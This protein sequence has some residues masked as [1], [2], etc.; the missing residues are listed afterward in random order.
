VVQGL[1]E[2][3]NGP[4]ILVST[5]RSYWPGGSMAAFEMPVHTPHTRLS[6]DNGEALISLQRRRE[7]AR[8]RAAELANVVTP[9]TTR[10][11]LVL[12]RGQ[13]E[14]LDF[15]T[16]CVRHKARIYGDWRFDQVR[17][18]GQGIVALFAGPSGT[19]KT[20]AAEVIAHELG[21]C[22]CQV[23]LSAIVSKYIGETEKNLRRIFE[24]A[25]D[26]DAVLTF[27]EG[28]AL[29]G[30]RSE[31][32]DSHDRYANIE[33]SHLLQELERYPGLVILT[34]NLKEAVDVAFKRRIHF[35]VEFPFPEPAQR[36]AIWRL[37]IP[38]AAPTEGLDCDRL[39]Q[40]NVAGGSIQNIALYA[41]VAAAQSGEPI[42]M[43]HVLLGARGEYAKLGRT[44][45]E[46]EIKGWKDIHGGDNA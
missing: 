18:R 30:K 6:L 41:A 2:Y 42:R 29:F 34:T 46:T 39:A 43:R 23:D 32:R 9:V 8:S 4:L 25:R 45:T 16:A 20:L 28:D 21:L 37:M 35:Y 26:A 10:E 24:A 11:R 15:I 13:W 22:L 27:D 19:G 40:L 1:A 38:S 12:P 3:L 31:V 17:P 14:T 33:V 36:A 44:L 5:R 7:R